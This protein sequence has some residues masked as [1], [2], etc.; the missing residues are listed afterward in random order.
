MQAQ[1]LVLLINSQK[2][3]VMNKKF[4][5]SI[6]FFL[7]TNLIFCQKDKDITN[8]INS[9]YVK[10]KKLKKKL[11]KDKLVKKYSKFDT[12]YILFTENLNAKKNIFQE[13]N[14]Q[15]DSS[16][17]YSFTV[18]DSLTF[19]FN[20]RKYLDFDK[21]ISNRTSLVITKKVSFLKINYKKIVNDNFFIINDSY[22]EEYFL[23]V[24]HTIFS[25]KKMI[26]IIDKDEFY[27]DEIIL[28]QVSIGNL[29]NPFF[30]KKI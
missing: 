17:N 21:R 11:N 5:I 16:I 27:K 9:E 30:I 19:G 8:E 26:Y 22:E 2:T 28:R 3:I 24:L 4:L 29:D 6:I 1:L 10:L 23:L 14:K 7:I 25:S 13:T 15:K 12:I 20:Y 18:K